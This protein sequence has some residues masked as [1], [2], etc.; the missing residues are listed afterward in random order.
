MKN[1]PV[2]VIDD[3]L[4]ELEMIQ[5]IWQDLNFTNKLETFS[6]IDQMIDRLK[7][8]INPFIII[9]DVNLPK[10]DGFALKQLLAEEPDVK[11]KSVP[12]V[13][14]STTASDEQIKKA[15]DACGHGFFIKGSTYTEIKDS[16]NI[17]MSYWHNSKAPQAN[18][19]KFSSG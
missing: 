6:S 19:S 3:D 16:L 8:N 7:E 14:W 11:Y 4:E 17:I 10:I 13:F 9:S 15:Y 18:G 12:F 1:A 2:F 5:D